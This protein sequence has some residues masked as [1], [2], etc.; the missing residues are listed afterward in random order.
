MFLQ[1]GR[2][3]FNHTPD[4]DLYKSLYTY[5]P[6]KAPTKTLQSGCLTG[7]LQ[8]ESP[9][10]TQCTTQTLQWIESRWHWHPKMSLMFWDPC[11]EPPNLGCQ[12]HEH[13]LSICKSPQSPA[14]HLG[15]DS[16]IPTAFRT[17]SRRMGAC[18]VPL[19]LLAVQ[20]PGAV[21]EKFLY[22]LAVL[23][24]KD[25][26]QQIHHIL[27]VHGVYFVLHFAFVLWVACSLPSLIASDCPATSDVVHGQP[28]T[29]AFNRSTSPGL[30]TL[31]DHL[32]GIHLQTVPRSTPSG[33]CGRAE[34]SVGAGA[35]DVD[36]LCQSKVRTQIISQARSG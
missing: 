10:Q 29:P 11:F 1:T 5:K 12:C 31:V 35:R 2:T 30:V 7:S 15:P 21:L 16:Q 32:Y 27:T 18:E 8:N 9:T 19:P 3:P 34:S 25:T 4:Y 14:P 33:R 20:L 26:I 24:L 13:S 22:L 28:P 17:R 23:D 6:P 36:V